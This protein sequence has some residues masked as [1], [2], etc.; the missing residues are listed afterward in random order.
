MIITLLSG[1]LGNQMFQFAAGEA[2][3]AKLGQ[4]HKLDTSFYSIYDT[5]RVYELDRVF[6]KQFELAT[7]ADLEK[8]LGWKKSIYFHPFW[9]RVYRK[10]PVSKDWVVEPGFTYWSNFWEQGK[11]CL[12]E[13]IW[14]SVKYFDNYAGI[15]R[16]ALQ[17]K[18]EEF[19]DLSL[20]EKI[21]KSNSVSI[22]IRRGDY[23]A[24]NKTF[25]YHGICEDEYYVKAIEHFRSRF[26]DIKLFIFS[27]DLEE[28]KKILKPY[29]SICHFVDGNSGDKSHFDMMLMS[30]CK[31]NIIA[32]STF[33]WWGAWLN[34]NPEKAVIAPKNWFSADISDKDLI[35]SSWIRV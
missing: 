34:Q 24:N 12:I 20:I 28:A 15:V 5:N 18:M 17:F 13:G 16:D 2:L 32:N 25:G 26:A 8:V 1:G 11:N 3:A 10:F 35:P 22:H 33:S 4:Q 14:Q 19:T 27:D 7:N 9:R 21:T 29:Q 31:H 30:R 23:V 6:A